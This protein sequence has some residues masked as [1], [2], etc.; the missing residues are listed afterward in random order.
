MGT[1]DTANGSKPFISREATG[2][3][4]TW[5]SAARTTRRQNID[6]LPPLQARTR[7]GPRNGQTLC[8]LRWTQE[9][10]GA[11]KYGSLS[12]RLPQENQGPRKRRQV[13]PEQVA[14]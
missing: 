14:S 4:A 8:E 11:A 7:Q 3:K 1:C 13:R 5:A 12:P 9:E 6:A 2:A 10:V